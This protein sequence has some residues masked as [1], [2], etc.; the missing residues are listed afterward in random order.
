MI[1]FTKAVATG[2][3]F[4]V[5]DNRKKVLKNNL[6]RLAKELCDRKYG[7]G[8][9][10]LLLLE[11]SDSADFKMRIFNPDGSEAQMCGN[12]SRCIALY[13]YKKKITSSSM[14]IET[15][16]G[17]ISASVN[18]D[19]VKVKLT[20]PKDIQWNL[21][22]MIHECPYKVN[23]ANTGVPHVIHFVKDI[24][25]ISVKELGSSMR[26]HADFSPEGANVDF[27]RIA[28]RNKKKIQVRTYERGVEDET[29][30]CGTGAVASAIIAAEAEDIS[31][32]ITVETRS[33]EMLKVHFEMVKGDFK[34]VYL[35][36]K[37][38]LV[39]EGEIQDV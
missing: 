36:G 37:A 6:A 7:I 26:Y 4:V 9:D 35:E 18:G 8:A 21:C 30:A 22:L 34:N 2:N 3:D 1:R 17:I 13:A 31:S 16:A 15:L 11:G 20:E 25:N 33:G 23:F 10:G 32:P 14:D 19:N 27:V 29:L 12:G 5:V 38:Q 39:Y 24:E 28:D